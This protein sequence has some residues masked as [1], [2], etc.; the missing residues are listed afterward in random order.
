M[1]CRKCQRER[2]RCLGVGVGGVGG[3][4]RDKMTIGKRWQMRWEQGGRD[5]QGEMEGG[6]S[7]TGVR[8][9]WTAWTCFPPDGPPS[10][11]LLAPVVFL[12]KSRGGGGGGSEV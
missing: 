3:V 9:G 4:Q 12:R 8:H 2:D 5:R 6:E 7:E 10:A 1:E 11:D